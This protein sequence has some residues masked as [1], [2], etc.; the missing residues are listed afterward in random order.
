MA[1]VTYDI[2]TA[3]AVVESPITMQQYII[4]INKA[5]S[6]PFLLPTDQARYH[7]VIM[8]GLNKFYRD[9]NGNLDGFKIPI[10][11]DGSKHFL[12]IKKP[13]KVDREVLP[14]IEL[15]S[16]ILWGTLQTHR[17]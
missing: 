14:I 17:R 9:S 13:T 16:P 1:S 2:M 11:H 8:N 10:Q 4:I 5:A 3:A 12:N 15:T 7:N 6:I